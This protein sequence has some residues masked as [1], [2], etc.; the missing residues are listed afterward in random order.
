MGM[1]T[2]PVEEAG[3]ARN[4]AL[5]GTLL[6]LAAE[7]RQESSMGITAEPLHTGRAGL[8]MK[9][10]KGLA[11][12]GLLA[13]AVGR[14]NRV[15]AGIAG[16]ALLA[17]SACARFGIFYAGQESA[18]DPKYTVVPQRERLTARGER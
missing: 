3:P 13:G 18:K 17:G 5:W 14:N 12:G 10:S 4:L 2:A 1:L 8:L 15:I 16:A 6:E 11:A 9:A 7:H